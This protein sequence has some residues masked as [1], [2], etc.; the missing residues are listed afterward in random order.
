MKNSD[1]IKEKITRE[2]AV[3]KAPDIWE[4]IEGG[5]TSAETNQKTV[6]KRKRLMKPILV[7]AMFLFLV[8]AAAASAPL[9]LKMLGGDIGFFDSQKQ[10]RYSADQELIKRYSSEVGL[11]AEKDG[12]SLTVDNI[13][14]DG[15]F[16][17]VFYTIKSE[18]NLLEETKE[19]TKDFNNP[20]IAINAL[21]VNEVRLEIPGYEFLNDRNGYENQD[22]YF[23]SDYE[24][25]GARRYTITK[26]LPE[27]FDIEISYHYF[28]NRLE[29]WDK[30]RGEDGIADPVPISVSLTVDMSESKIEAVVVA[31][32]LNAAIRQPRFAR[33]S[34]E[35]ESEYE[36]YR[37]ILAGDFDEDEDIEI[38]N[39]DIKYLAD[40]YP[41]EVVHNIIIDRVKMS[42]LG[43]ILVM[44]EKGGESPVNREL[45][46]KY[47]IV[48]DKGKFYGRTN[49]YMTSRNDWEKDETSVVEFYGSAPDDIQYLKLVPYNGGL[50]FGVLDYAE[51][52][53][54]PKKLNFSK[55]GSVTIESCEITDEAVTFTY[56]C[57]GMV[58][59]PLFTLVDENKNH[60]SNYSWIMPA[61]DRNANL[62][63]LVYTFKKPLENAKDIV[64]GIGL[65][66]M[67]IE[68]L[69]DQAVIIPLK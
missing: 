69:D 61:A 51:L 7:A 50:D 3:E 42:P 17:N 38:E 47:Y 53:N 20:Y 26:N 49:F 28:Y 18:K 44:T 16:L 15:T 27:V 2:F 56:R 66:C 64:K 8:T 19:I 29:F 48:D 25:K 30:Y 24:L 21:M 1:Y 10:M 4:K 13:A 65:Y 57:E 55:Y 31:P 58:E 39:I 33:F 63:T 11:S 36:D 5:I 52:N 62:Y 41:S 6:K 14:F 32:N 60:L 68:L 9:I 59:E 40:K 45:L 43:N 46:N 22:G 67:D 54:L 35:Y 12:F 37:R 23:A 34:D